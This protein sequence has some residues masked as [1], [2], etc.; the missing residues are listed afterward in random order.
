M[1]YN[2]LG[3]FRVAGLTGFL[4]SFCKVLA[5]ASVVRCFFVRYLHV[6][7]KKKVQKE[8][9]QNFNSVTQM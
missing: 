3:M 4:H 1:Y 5:L 2:I 6:M 7:L 8:E 9:K